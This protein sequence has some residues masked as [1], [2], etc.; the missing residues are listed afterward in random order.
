MWHVKQN[1][2]INGLKYLCFFGIGVNIQTHVTKSLVSALPHPLPYKE[3]RGQANRIHHV[4]TKIRNGNMGFHIFLN[5]Y[6]KI[7]LGVFDCGP[8]R[9]PLICMT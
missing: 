2:F 1:V 5:F 9:F 8:S 7:F 6:K 3:D 4:Y